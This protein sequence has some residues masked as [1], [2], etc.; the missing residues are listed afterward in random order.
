VNRNASLGSV[1]S[2]NG[3]GEVD[4]TYGRTAGA[5]RSL[6]AGEVRLPK[7]DTAGPLSD[8]ATEGGSLAQLWG[9]AFQDRLD[10]ERPTDAHLGLACHAGEGCGRADPQASVSLDLHGGEV[11]GVREVDHPRGPFHVQL[12]EIEK[13]SAARK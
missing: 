9:E 5:R 8:V 7:I 2:K 10:E 6:V 1:A 11:R 13:A 4:A 12:H 3:V